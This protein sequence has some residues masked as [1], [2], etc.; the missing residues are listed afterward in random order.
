MSNLQ[1]VIMA[2]G[3]GSRYGGLKQIDE[4]GPAQEY[5]MDYAIYDAHKAGINQDCV[6]VRDHFKAEIQQIMAK[7]WQAYK[8][9]QFNFVS[10]ETTDLPVPFRGKI[11]R[12]KPWGTAHILFVLRNI[13]KTPF[14]IMNADDFY[15]REAI[16]SLSEF[17]VRKPGEHALVSYELQK[18][19]SL[20]G[21]VT[22]GICEIKNDKLVSIDEVSGIEPGDQR[23]AFASMNLWG[24]SPQAFSHVEELFVRFLEKNADSP[25]AEYQIPTMVNDLLQEKR[26]EITAIPT[27]SDWFGVTYKED[28]DL[29]KN[30]IA[31][32]VE[33][34]VY[35][36]NLF[37]R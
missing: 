19:L 24:F 5:L 33:R 3:L 13:L 7:K 22:R 34:G 6:I 27:K 37:A 21:A 30:K 26:I 2:A 8:D 15:G 18:T 17:L 4:F 29:V 16:Q 9:L 28:K 25:K 20:H 23:H 11:Q 35:P 10:Q 14:V 32:L 1:V 36:E 12:E 31:S